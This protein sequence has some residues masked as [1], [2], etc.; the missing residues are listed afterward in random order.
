VRVALRPFVDTGAFR[1][2]VTL[3]QGDE[4]SRSRYV[5]AMAEVEILIDVQWGDMDALGHV[6]NAKFFSWFESARIAL[7]MKI[8]VAIDG[9]GVGPILATTQCDF[10]KPVVYPATVRIRAR[11]TKIGETSMTMEYGVE[12]AKDASVR[13]ARGTSVAV[14]V[15]YGTG[16]KVRVPDDVRRR[17]I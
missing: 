4:P 10:L 11:L 1:A 8:G 5:V 14:L 7:F 9:G 15:E 6:N 12:D 16:Q 3:A 13:Y 17:S 2:F